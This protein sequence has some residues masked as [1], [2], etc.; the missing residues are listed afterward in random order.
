M[1]HRG[2]RIRL[3]M[4]TSAPAVTLERPIRPAIGEVTAV[5]PT[6]MRA[7]ST[8]ARAEATS[9]SGPFE[10]GNGIVVGLFADRLD[11]HQVP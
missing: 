6:S 10:C 11:L 2:Q 9:A 5:K 8:A 4:V 1:L 7:F 3:V